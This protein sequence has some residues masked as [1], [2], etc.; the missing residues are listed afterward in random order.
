MNHL[1]DKFQVKSSAKVRFSIYCRS[2]TIKRL[3]N[4]E[5]QFKKKF[6]KMRMKSISVFCYGIRFRINVL[7]ISKCQVQKCISHIVDHF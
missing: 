5:N 6:K 4:A 2:E 3:V 7:N 1:F